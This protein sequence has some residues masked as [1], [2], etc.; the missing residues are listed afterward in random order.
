VKEDL[1]AKMETEYLQ[2]KDIH[3]AYCQN[4]SGKNLI[5]LHGNSGSKKYFA[6]YQLKYFS[7]FNSFAIDSRGHGQSVS[8]DR[9]LSYEQMSLDIVDFCKAKGIEEA[10]VI[11]YSDGGNLALWLA[12]KAPQIFD[13]VVAISPNTLASGADENSIRF[14]QNFIKRRKWL[15]HISPKIRKQ[16]MRFNLMLTDSGITD[17]LL[18][19]IRTKVMI[20]YAEQDM[21]REE[22]ILDIASKIPGCALKKIGGCTHFDIA[23]QEEAISEMQKFLL[24]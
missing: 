5:L 8:N 12:V 22:H 9:E 14:V 4:G 6:N 11:G 17:E 23:Y 2:L 10:S 13:Q 7:E 20:L 15:M 1:K 3:L 21:I 19:K 16:V 18:T 24:E